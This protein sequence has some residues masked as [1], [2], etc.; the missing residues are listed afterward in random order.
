MREKRSMRLPAVDA[1]QLNDEQQRL[2]EMLMSRP[3]VAAMGLVGPFGVWMHAPDVGIA[4]SRLGSKVRF[5]TSLPANV[6]EVAICTTGAYHRAA[7]EFA[8]HRTMAITAGVDADR[9]DILAAGRDPHFEG[10]EAAASAVATEL[11]RDHR[12][13]AATYADAVERFGHRGM[14]ELVT[15][16][17]YYGLISMLLNGFEV[18]L[19][20]G[21]T[22][23]FESGTT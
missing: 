6:T 5:S 10:D 17:G 7:F 8:A 3:E 18:P 13:S 12:I 19:A 4:M 16:V 21:M 23:P 11:L 14:V 1:D 15:T 20:E 22:D 9:L 2:H